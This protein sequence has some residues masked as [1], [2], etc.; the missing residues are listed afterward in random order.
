MTSLLKLEKFCYLSDTIGA[1]GGTNVIV[2]TRI[3][4]ALSSEILC[5]CW[6]DE[7]YPLKQETLY[8]ACVSSV[9]IYG[10]DTLP[11]KE[12]YV[13]SLERNDPVM[14]RWIFN[15]S[16]EDRISE[17]ELSIRLKFESMREMFTG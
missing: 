14:V 3:R 11:V 9:M 15:V 2:I 5:L 8:C 6:P 16:P 1:K 10:I 4:S 17:E 13:I 12:K 7:I